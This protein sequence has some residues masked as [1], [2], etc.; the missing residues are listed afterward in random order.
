MSTVVDD[1]IYLLYFYVLL[2]TL[3]TPP[4]LSVV[5]QYNSWFPPIAG[6]LGASELNCELLMPP[7]LD[8]RLL[9]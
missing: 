2:K 8:V 6:N 9:L 5:S 4:F 1:I 7:L 3:L